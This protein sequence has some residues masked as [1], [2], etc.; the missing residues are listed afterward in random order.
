MILW[1]R[2]LMPKDCLPP[3]TTA[4]DPLLLRYGAFIQSGSNV[5]ESSGL[6]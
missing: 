5:R 2:K 1:E 6:R 3:T 4:Y